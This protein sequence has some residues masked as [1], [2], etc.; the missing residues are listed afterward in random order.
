MTVTASPAVAAAESPSGNH[1]APIPGT[2]SRCNVVD[3]VECDHRIGSV[4]D[5]IIGPHNN[6]I[7][8]LD[9]VQAGGN[10]VGR[11]YEPS[12]HSASRCDHND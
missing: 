1:G 12:A 7:R 5:S 9:H 6:S 4:L 2:E 11:D 10:A 8:A 3:P